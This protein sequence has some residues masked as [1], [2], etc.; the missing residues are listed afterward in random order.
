MMIAKNRSFHEINIK[1]MGFQVHIPPHDEVLLDDVVGEKLQEI[2]PALHYF[3]V[4]RSE[5][6]EVINRFE[7]KK[8]NDED[9]KKA[10]EKRVKAQIDEMN[11]QREEM[12]ELKKKKHEK[13]NKQLAD[14]KPAAEI[15]GRGEKVSAKKAKKI[16]KK[17]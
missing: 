11:K 7:Q 6:D 14:E 15:K 4:P 3:N 9:A 16:S 13:I 17:K 12:A 8:E 10:E 5:E 1:L 2:Q